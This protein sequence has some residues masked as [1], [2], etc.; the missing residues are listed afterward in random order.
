MCLELE[1]LLQGQAVDAIVHERYGGVGKGGHRLGI[2]SH[3]FVSC[4]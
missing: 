1:L 4:R 3:L 2:G